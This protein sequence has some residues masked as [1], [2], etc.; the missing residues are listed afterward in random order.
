MHSWP[1]AHTHPHAT[2]QPSQRLT[3]YSSLSLSSSLP[4]VKTATEAAFQKYMGHFGPFLSLGLSNYEE[5]Q[6]CAVA[7]GVVGDICRALEVKV[8]PYC[9]EIISLLLRN[10]QNPALNRNVKPPI[11][12]CFGDIA[13]AVG[14]HFEKYMQVTMSMLVQA[15][16]TAIDASNPDLVDYLNQLREGIFEA[17]T[18][19]LQGLRADDKSAAFEPYVMGTLDLIRQVAEG[20]PN[21]TTNDDVLRAAAGVVGDLGS[22]LGARGVKQFARQPPHREYLKALLKEA[23]SSQNPQTKE[24]GV[25][26]YNALFAGAG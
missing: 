16:S 21:G 3:L 14:G 23:K 24:V 25:W 6:V 26:A 17:Y 15:S 12:S 1:L 10:L 4:F 13:L 19:V 20:I 7:I 9:D 18:G 2:L 8:L 5:H 22:S 11:L